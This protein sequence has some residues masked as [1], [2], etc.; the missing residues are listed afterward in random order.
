[1]RKYIDANG[2]EEVLS[3]I[4]VDGGLRIEESVKNFVQTCVKKVVGA[5]ISTQG[6]YPAYATF[7]KRQDIQP[8]P[9]WIFGRVV[10]KILGKH[11]RKSNGVRLWS[12]YAVN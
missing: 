12:G 9:V 4:L 10:V 7:C 5:E 1:M 3:H 11:T 2:N 8:Q 6:I